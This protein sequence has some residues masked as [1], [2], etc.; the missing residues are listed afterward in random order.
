MRTAPL[1]LVLASLGFASPCF[2]A[3]TSSHTTAKAAFAAGKRAFEGEQ[4][5]QALVEFQ[6]AFELSPH[7]AVRFN[8]AV[9]L[10]RLGRF[11]EA[12]KEYDAAAASAALPESERERAR[13]S[14]VQ[15]R[16]NVAVVAVEG[17][18]N[19]AV[20]VDGS[21]RCK[22]P[23]ELELDPGRHAISVGTWQT[24]VV[25]VAGQ[26]S[27]VLV[28][29]PAPEP[30]A[31]AQPL[32][33]PQ[34]V[35]EKPRPQAIAPQSKP[36]EHDAQPAKEGR[37]PGALTWTGASVALVGA[38]A[39]TYFWLHATDL[40]ESYDESPKQDELDSGN[41]AVLFTNVSL[42]V[43]AVGAA[44]IAVDLIFFAPE[45]ESKSAR[46]SLGTFRF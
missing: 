6:R 4:F 18:E 36:V 40:K 19:G 38:G 12:A 46:R 30:V 31:E 25:A 1:L 14:A 39:A 11:S 8:V 35:A 34:P 43:A 24:E 5:A 26:S 13:R 21:E 37:G 9:C 28:P 3:E 17:G 2:A 20:L 42:G 33:K 44:L 23:C 45:P 29:A 32:P 10:E 27:K 15:A 7:D 16:R 22:A 41:Q